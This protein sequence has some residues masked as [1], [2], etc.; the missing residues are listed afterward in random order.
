MN[1]VPEK[2]KVYLDISI[3]NYNGDND[4]CIKLNVGDTV[5]IFE[6]L[7]EWYFGFALHNKAVRGVFPKTFIQVRECIV[8]K[9]G[10]SE[11]VSARLPPIVHEVT[12]VLRE[13][14]V[15][16]RKLYVEEGSNG[17]RRRDGGELKFHRVKDCM[18]Q[19]I[20]YRSTIL[21]GTLPGDELKQLKQKITVKIDCINVL[22]GL[23][24][25]VRDDAGNILNP[26]ITS[27]VKLFRH[28]H[29]ADN[30]IKKL[31]GAED[32]SGS[33]MKRK[34][35]ICWTA[36][37]SI[38]NIIIRVPESSEIS[39]GLFTGDPQ[40][41]TER[42]LSENFIVRWTEEGYNV[43]QELLFKT[44]CLYTDLSTVTLEEKQV[45]L[46]GSIVR[47]GSMINKESDSKRNTQLGSKKPP[48]SDAMKRPFGMV[49]LDV[50]EEVKKLKASALN[51]L[52]SSATVESECFAPLHL[53]GAAASPNNNKTIKTKEDP[54]REEYCKLFFSHLA[55][56]NVYSQISTQS[57]YFFFKGEVQF[58]ILLDLLSE[59]LSFDLKDQIYQSY[60]QWDF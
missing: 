3:Y 51:Q 48:I 41:G 30:N 14:G 49:I 23:D 46:L 17:Y 26:D 24:L 36:Y 40:N 60:W 13:W 39:I 1:S 25:V 43:N 37:I 52:G 18:M 56:K 5:H 11:V 6:E 29:E 34:P 54:L 15:L 10:P 42:P 7:G 47:E 2:K 22:L 21:S 32:S 50:T 44:K 28:H 45:W 4:S 12:A 58:T 59:I 53:C 20:C 38:S 33:I 35:H 19:L 57:P 27:A 16:L 8:D 31:K 9:T 55:I